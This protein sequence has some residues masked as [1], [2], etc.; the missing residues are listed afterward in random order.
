MVLTPKAFDLLLTLMENRDR[1]LSKDELLEKVWP[2]TF[3]EEGILKYNVSVLRK[4]LGE[5]NWIETQPRRGYRFAGEVI[6][7]ST[8]GG[9]VAVVEKT[10]VAVEVEAEITTA[11]QTWRWVAAGLALAAVALGVMWW[12]RAA[13]DAGV[14]TMAVLP[15]QTL[16]AAGDRAMELGITDSLITRLGAEGPWLVR[17][18][19]A[20]RGFSGAD[21]DPVA[22][23]RKLEVDAIMDGS[24]QRSEN[25]LRLTLQLLRVRDGRHL[26]TG[27][28]DEKVTDLFAME[29]RIAAEVAQ[30]LSVKLRRAGDR[31]S[32]SDPEVY[33]K[34]LEGRHY[35]IET[36]PAA[37]RRA[38][39]S[40]EAALQ[41][42][43]GFA[44]AYGMLALSY[45]Q[46]AQRGGARA[47]EVAEQIRAAANKAVELDPA[48][49]EGHTALSLAK[50][51]L[52]YD[53][54][55]AKQ[56]YERALQL[57][58]HEPLVHVAFGIHA[59]AHGRFHEAEQA[60]IVEL[61]IFPQSLMSLVGRGYPALYEGRY[62]DAM[63]W[64]R[65]ALEIDPAFPVAYNDLAIAYNLKGMYEESIQAALKHASLTGASPEEI[66]RR[67]AIFRKEGMNGYR[68][69][70][71]R[72]IL[73]REARGERVSPVSIAGF[74]VGLGEKA[75]ALDYLERAVDE[76][77]FQ[78]LTLGTFPQWKVLQGEARYHGL[79]RK[80]RL[81]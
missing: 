80:M 72:S 40:L 78:I 32:S 14:R 3:V 62:D 81:E 21:R 50:M 12:R 5:Q 52:D 66:A 43:S 48:N 53:W 63:V 64:Y 73:E 75:K 76:H 8:A 25:R 54:D 39:Q 44:P 20:V 59:I 23:G 2:G 41:R 51:W 74:Y 71:L 36:T 79:L 13:P 42:D 45:W 77:T 17:P 56:E 4:A 67:L 65:K 9:T 35:F 49:A 30:A 29:D 61:E 24:L 47:A 33:E 26:W 19:G 37:T 15:F 69:D 28:F 22:A 7:E 31:R 68:R 55:G 70:A 34:Y 11:S 16:T 46:L 18:M 58:P 38:I 57:N 60:Y 10:E 6:E 1:L 27:K